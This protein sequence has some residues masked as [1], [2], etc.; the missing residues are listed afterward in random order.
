MDLEF[1]FP[2]Y[3]EA[4]NQAIDLSKVASQKERY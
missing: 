1:K 2:E 3:T 4:M